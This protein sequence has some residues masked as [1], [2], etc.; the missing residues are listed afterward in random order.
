MAT[1]STGFSGIGGSTP[2]SGTFVGLFFGT[3]GG[4]LDRYRVDWGDGSAVEIFPNTASGADHFF[5]L[6]LMATIIV[7]A[8]FTDAPTETKRLKVQSYQDIAPG[9]LF[10]GS[11]LPDLI[12][13]GTGDDTLEGFKGDDWLF[14]GVGND[15][16]RGG[17]GD[18][19]LGG[20]GGDPGNDTLYGGEGNDFLVGD[21]GDDKLYGGTGSD[22]L[23]GGEG[24]DTLSGGADGE[25]DTFS[26]QVSQTGTGV[27]RITDFE[28]GIDHILIQGFGGAPVDIVI[29]DDPKPLTAGVAA[30]LY[31]TD[32]GRLYLDLDGKGGAPRVQIAVLSGAPLLTADDFI[33]A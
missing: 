23:E 17:K 31:D 12:A 15:L 28:V 20:G 27:D 13:T 19:F 5:G 9:A 6:N 4:T 16:A 1:L 8:I 18:D 7:R 3:S 26:F 29:N 32:N 10:S 21:E 22:F 30:V 33:L 2:P 14:G 25:I 24:S 11:D